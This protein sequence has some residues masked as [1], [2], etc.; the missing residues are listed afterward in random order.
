MGIH[1]LSVVTGGLESRSDG[2]VVPHAGEGGSVSLGWIYQLIA[3][4]RARG[5]D[6]YKCLRRMG[7]KRR[8]KTDAGRSRIP[9]G[10]GVRHAQR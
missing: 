8:A 4:D 7:K 3:G 9:N 2:G 6:L 1:H 5:G 10:W